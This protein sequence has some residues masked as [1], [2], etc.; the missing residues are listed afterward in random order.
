[1]TLEL[2]VL[3]DDRTGAL[4]TAGECAD[5][6]FTVVMTPFAA[7]DEL[8][9][10]DCRVVDLGT[11]RLDPAEAARR[12]ASVKIDARRH[13]HKID[14][15][16][17]G[18]WPAEITARAMPTLL[19]PAF[20]SAH[21]ICIGGVVHVRDRPVGRPADQLPD[22]TVCDATTDRDL[23]RH[24]ITWL[25]DPHLL[26]AGTAGAI[27]AGARA[28]GRPMQRHIPRASGRVL[29]VCGSR[30][31]IALAQAAAVADRHEIVYEPVAPRGDVFVIVG[32]DTAAA[33]LGDRAMVVGG[34]IEPGVAWSRFAD[35]TGPLVVTKPGG[36]GDEQTLTRVLAAILEP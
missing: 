7:D 4:E 36:F 25:A 35:G 12:A 8:P 24:A 29:V 16:L 31:P 18:N 13:G 22:A 14:S 1:M 20:P 33:V 10:H 32:G 26:L 6:G 3:A 9:D 34:T 28:L 19:V 30:Q 2:L 27:G 21:R 17:K 15:T 23:D 5:A 11:R